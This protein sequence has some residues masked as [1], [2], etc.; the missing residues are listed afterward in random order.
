MNKKLENLED[1]IYI[2]EKLKEDFSTVHNKAPN[3]FNFLAQA[4]NQFVRELNDKNNSE[5][6]VV[7]Y[8]FS[9][10]EIN[11][12]IKYIN[13]FADVKSKKK[14]YKFKFDLDKNEE[15]NNGEYYQNNLN[16]IDMNSYN[17]KDYFK[18]YFNMFKP[19]KDINKIEEIKVTNIKNNFNDYYIKNK[20][21]SLNKYITSTNMIRDS[22]YSI[23]NIKNS[24]IENDTNESNK[25]YKYL[26]DKDRLNLLQMYKYPKKY[27]DNNNF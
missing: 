9:H 11:K 23:S 21:D 7:Q 17:Y 25:L 18:K 22:L 3:E 14:V 26:K 27:I 5:I 2:S 1:I 4:F 20:P 10:D 16:L 19:P 24:S 8:N 13:S 15:K 12:I 6:N